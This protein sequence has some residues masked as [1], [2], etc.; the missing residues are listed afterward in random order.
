MQGNNRVLQKK[1][2]HMRTNS[3]ISV[4]SYLCIRDSIL[5][6]LVS[7]ADSKGIIERFKSM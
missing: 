3:L 7:I 5:K 6:E 4:Y 1:E 2:I